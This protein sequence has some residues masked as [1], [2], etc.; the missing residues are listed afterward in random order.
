MVRDPHVVT[1]RSP[2]GIALARAAA[3]WS[4][5]VLGVL[6]AWYSQISLRVGGLGRV[7]LALVVVAIGA[8]ALA[9]VAHSRWWRIRPVQAW[10]AWWPVSYTHL[11]VYK[12]QPTRRSTRSTRWA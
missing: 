1:P 11:D 6:L 2:R 12:R 9:N 8:I 10:L 7:P 3:P 4:I 5:A